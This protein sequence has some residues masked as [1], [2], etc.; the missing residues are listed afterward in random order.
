MKARSNALGVAIAFGVLVF[1]VLASS[2]SPKTTQIPLTII[3]AHLYLPM[4]LAGQ[5]KQHWWLVDTG[6][7]WS[8]INIEHVKQ[9]VRSAPG[10]VEQSATVAD[11]K[12]TILVNIGTN[13][14]GYP[15]GQFD[16]FEASV[17]NMTAG[18]RGTGDT[19]GDSFE[20][21]GVLGVNFLARHRARL[22]FR[23]QRLSFYDGT[24]AAALERAGFERRGYTCIPIRLTVVG[25]IEVIGSVGANRYSFLL[26]SGSPETILRSTIKEAAW[27][28]RAYNGSVYFAL[29]QRA[30]ASSGRLPGFKLGTQDMSGDVVQFASIPELQTGFRYPLGGIIGED[31][32]WNHQAVLDIGGGALYLKPAS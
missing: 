17:A 21:G 1:Q 2:V 26:D 3:R 15:M 20:A 11:K 25:R 14:D 32:L 29:G 18:N 5:G 10:I 28:F 24:I 6:S 27:L 13:V 22:D 31:L 4:A 9:L 23:S 12:C 16:F 8:L 30:G 19:Y 7:P